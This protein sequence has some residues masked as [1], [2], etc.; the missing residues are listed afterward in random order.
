[1]E[2]NRAQLRRDVVVI[3]ASAGGLEPLLQLVAAIPPELPVII[4]AVLHR[5]PFGPS[6]LA[7][8]L[9]RRARRTVVEPLEIVKVDPGVIYL[10]PRDMHIVFEDGAVMGQRS[11]KQHFTRPAVDP[12]FMSAAALYGSRVLGILLSGGGADGVLGLI[13]I[14]LKGGL[15]LVQ[16]PDEARQP[17]M[18]ATA[19]RED[20]VDAA[21]SVSQLLNVV[22]ALAQG[23]RVKTNSQASH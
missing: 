17:S 16:R 19:L 23:K 14:K 7:E 4:A 11:A 9:R 6:V 2:L 10:G 12:L 1:M 5:S 13:Q 20:D 3:G 18:P 22:P 21:L 8:L 15:T